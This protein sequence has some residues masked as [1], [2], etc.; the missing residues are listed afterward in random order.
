M[1]GFYFTVHHAQYGKK[2]NRFFLS[3]IVEFDESFYTDRAAVNPVFSIVL[4]AV[5]HGLFGHT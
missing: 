1:Q 2:I 5:S 3:P 4:E